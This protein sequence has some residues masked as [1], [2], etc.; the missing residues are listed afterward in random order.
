MILHQFL[1]AMA[2]ENRLAIINVLINGEQKVNDILDALAT[3]GLALSQPALSQHL[4]VLHSAGVV[5]SRREG[6]NVFYYISNPR[7]GRVLD[8]VTETVKPD[9]TKV[10]ESVMHK[11]REALSKLAKT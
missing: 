1:S 7:V 3:D 4:R 11:N 2:N 5:E 9:W 8:A 10:G 6:R